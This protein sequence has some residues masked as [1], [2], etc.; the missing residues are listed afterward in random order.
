MADI[1]DEQQSEVI[2]ITGGDEQYVADVINEDGENKLLVKSSIVP[3]VIGN[4]FTRF[5]ENGG[6]RQ[7][8]V[9][10]FPVPVEFI[11]NADAAGDLIVSSLVF[12][13]F[14]SGIKQDNFLGL[15][16]GLSN[17]VVVEVKSQDTTFQ[18]SPI[19]YT[20]EFNSVFATGAGRSYD[21]VQA[22]GNDSLVSR[23]GPTSP[24]IIRKQGTYATDDYIKVIIQDDIDQV[25]SLRFIASGSLKI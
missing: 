11:I 9:D 19:Q 23:F 25:E 16:S 10:G 2:R 18:F 22:S 7:M 6:S 13:A 1:T 20:V 17:G 15:N 5:A 3:E 14:D 4:R 24:F 8:A 12:E 21:I